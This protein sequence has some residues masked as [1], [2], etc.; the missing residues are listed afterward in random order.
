MNS[1]AIIKTG[2]KQY[3][4][5][6]GDT[7]LVEKISKNSEGA[8]SFDEVLL[9][10]HDNSIQ[11]GKPKVEKAKVKAKILDII[12]DKKIKVVKFKP[13]ARQLKTQ[14]HRQQKTKILIE[15]ITS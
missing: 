10:S 11:I 13:K 5:A 2:G 14:G 12:K 7:I 1:F 6:E 9:I 15:K 8:I 3:K 4:V